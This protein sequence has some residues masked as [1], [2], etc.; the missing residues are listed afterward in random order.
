MEAARRMWTEGPGWQRDEEGGA[1]RI[2]V[3]GG[4]SEWRIR[5]AWR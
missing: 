2:Q 5:R 3:N 4:F 1:H